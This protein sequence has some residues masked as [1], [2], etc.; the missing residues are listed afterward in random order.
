VGG[1][2]FAAVFQSVLV[3]FVLHVALPAK[4]VEKGSRP[5]KSKLRAN[6]TVKFYREGCSERKANPLA[7]LLGHYR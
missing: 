5:V 4:R 3:G 1:I 2:Q 7:F 6:F